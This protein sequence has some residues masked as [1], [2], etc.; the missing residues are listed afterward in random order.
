[1]SR[2]VQGFI[3]LADKNKCIIDRASVIFRLVSFDWRKCVQ[4]E[5]KRKLLRSF[6]VVY[7][8]EHK[9]IEAEIEKTPIL[10]SIMIFIF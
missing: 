3:S 7:Y 9:I 10:I 5:Q 6:Y 1:V 8:V 2:D 4:N